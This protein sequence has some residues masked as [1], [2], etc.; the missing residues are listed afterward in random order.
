MWNSFCKV[1]LKI[2]M[3]KSSQRGSEFRA[4]HIGQFKITCNSSFRESS[5]LFS[6]LQVYTQRHFFKVQKM[7]IGKQICILRVLCSSQWRFYIVT[8]T[9]ILSQCILNQV[10]NRKKTWGEGSA[11]CHILGKCSTTKLHSQHLG[12]RRISVVYRASFRLAYKY[13]RPYTVTICKNMLYIW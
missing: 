10:Q 11:R 12:G 6:P 4:T 13:T 8:L 1:F 2:D 7:Y 9:N 5:V 3:V